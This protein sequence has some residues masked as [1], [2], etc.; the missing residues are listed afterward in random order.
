M[1]LMPSSIKYWSIN[2][3]KSYVNYTYIN[4]NIAEKSEIYNSKGKSFIFEN[5]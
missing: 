2:L 5:I 4:F 3:L 1:Y